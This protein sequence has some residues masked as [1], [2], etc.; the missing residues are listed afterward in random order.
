MSKPLATDANKSAEP[1]LTHPVAT[2]DAKSDQKPPLLETPYSPFAS[3][4]ALLELPYK[5]YAEKSEPEAPY[6]PYKGM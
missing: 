5:P 2:P 1:S 6:E 4:P 3:M